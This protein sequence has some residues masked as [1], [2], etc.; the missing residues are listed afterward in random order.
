MTKNKRFMFAVYLHLFFE[1]Q[2][3]IGAPKPFFLGGGGGGVEH[4]AKDA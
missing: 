2:H 1:C 3:H 4:G